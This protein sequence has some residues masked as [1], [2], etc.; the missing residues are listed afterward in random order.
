MSRERKKEEREKGGLRFYIHMHGWGM[1]GDAGFLSRDGE[2]QKEKRNSMPKRREKDKH[3]RK[4]T[5]RRRDPKAF[6]DREKLSG[7]QFGESKR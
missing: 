1:E 3:D 4:E 7:V 5:W 6:D 2:S